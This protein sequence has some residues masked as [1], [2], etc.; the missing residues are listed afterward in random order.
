MSDVRFRKGDFIEVTD[1]NGAV[2][3]GTALH[4]RRFW[5]WASFDLLLQGRG[6]ILTFNLNYVEVKRLFDASVAR[7]MR[8]GE[9]AET[10]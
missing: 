7:D 5:G 6:D 8:P 2:Y 9:D 1:E 4:T 3:R 10:F